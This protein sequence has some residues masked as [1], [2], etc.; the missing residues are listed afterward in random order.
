LPLLS[1]FSIIFR[2]YFAF[3][4]V[5]GGTVTSHEH[6][7]LPPALETP[8]PLEPPAL[9][10]SSAPVPDQASALQCLVRHQRSSAW[11][12]IS[13]PVPDQASALQCLT[14]LKRSSAMGQWWQWWQGRREGLGSTL[15]GTVGSEGSTLRAPLVQPFRAL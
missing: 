6:Q 3:L 7:H 11:P 8:V 10:T 14:R 15:K 4:R 12:G 5:S 13:A 9:L 1:L 2:A